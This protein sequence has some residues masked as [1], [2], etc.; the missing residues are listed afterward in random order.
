MSILTKQLEHADFLQEFSILR[1][2][3][4][5]P[6][7]DDFNDWVIF[8]ENA[9]KDVFSI[10]GEESAFLEILLINNIMLL[11]S[12]KFD[13]VFKNLEKS[14]EILFNLTKWPLELISMMQ[15]FAGILFEEQ[16]MSESEREYL[17][18]LIHYFV[19]MGDPRG[20]GS[21]SSNFM[22]G[23]A[24][25][26]SMVSH[27]FKKQIDAE[28]WEEILDSA[29]FNLSKARDY[30]K[31]S[32]SI[33][34]IPNSGLSRKFSKFQGFIPTKNKFNQPAR[35][36][37]HTRTSINT[38]SKLNIDDIQIDM[39]SL[40]K[41]DSGDPFDDIKY[42]LTENKFLFY[43]WD[44]YKSKTE[45]IEDYLRYGAGNQLD[46]FVWLL[47]CNPWMYM[48]GIKFSN[49]QIRDFT[50][51]DGV[52]NMLAIKSSS[53]II[54]GSQPF[55]SSMSQISD[56]SNM[57]SPNAKDKKQ[58]SFHHGAY[59]HILNKDHYG[60]SRSES[61]GIVYVWGTDV[62][63]Q[64]GWANVA[65]MKFE[66]MDDDFKRWYPRILI[67]LK[68]H[69]IKEVCCGNEH[70]LAVTIEG[71]I[72]SW[73]SNAYKQLG[74]GYNTPNF[75]N[76]PTRVYNVGSVSKIS[77]G[78]EHSVAL[79]DSGELY[80]WGHGEGGLLGHGELDD[81]AVPKMVLEFR[82]KGL[83]VSKVCWGGLH[84]LAIAGD[85]ELFT[86][87]RGE[88][89]QLGLSKKSL[90][91][92]ER[93]DWGISV[94][95]SIIKDK[96]IIDIAAG[97]AHSIAL[98]EDGEVYGWGNSNY[99]QLGLGFSGES[100][101]PGTGNAESSIYEPTL[102]KHLRGT[103]IARV[104]A[105]S[106]FTMFL[107]K[108]EEL[109]AWGT[110]DLG[111]CGIDTACEELK[112]F[113]KIKDKATNK[114][115]TDLDINLPRKLEWFS[116]M[117]VKGVAWGENHSF[118]VINIDDK[119][120]KMIWG[121]GMFKQ[122]QLGLG[123]VRKKV[124]PRLVQTLYNTTIDSDKVSWGS[125]NTLWIIGDSECFN[126]KKNSPEEDLDDDTSVFRVLENDIWNI[127]EHRNEENYD[128]DEMLEN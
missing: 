111:Q 114:V 20:R 77:W 22:I 50:F 75:V 33:T 21:Y 123:E 116:S 43:H 13:D 106:T 80:S 52:N 65:N 102:I 108:E 112:N 96:T 97:V 76:I 115:T 73:G 32:R 90:E 91:S 25:K 24:W 62:Q 45:D 86:W 89:G 81:Q 61:N 11:I 66:D 85:G 121:W 23:L 42:I 8:I 57:N 29:I 6:S 14:R 28:L 95:I 63:G 118:A 3:Y 99:G 60:M 15:L 117:K 68:D 98:S 18:A 38:D 125:S 119:N 53:S 113:E 35:M 40:Y 64:L 88:G 49:S 72:Y 5:L 56:N 103:E 105:G 126:I 9:F 74:I 120:K 30:V 10:E 104:Y 127:V 67:G 26:A 4:S 59:Q 92:L 55:S 107:S 71:N 69:I 84:T 34:G 12:N 78:Y 101:E 36:N 124:N 128:E 2:N 79:T 7:L 47:R 58:K 94:P 1:Q 48:S 19:V 54:S 17:M 70:S 41:S 93:L 110:N 27:Y 109:Y 39:L 51:S 83:K 100:F 31:D 37:P 44:L 46:Y 87:G 82:K 122:G 16:N